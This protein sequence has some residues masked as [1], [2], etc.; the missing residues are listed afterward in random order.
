MVKER[1]KESVIR[2]VIQL[3][4]SASEAARRFH[5]SE[6]SA[7]R[8]VQNYRRSGNFGGRKAGSGSWKIS[9]PEQDARLVAEIQRNPFHTSAT[10]KAVVN[11]P[12]N[13]QTVVNRL[14]AANLRSRPV[15]P[16]EV[17]EEHIEQR[18]V[19]AAGND[20]QDWKKVIF[21]DEL[22]FSTTKEEPTFVYRPPGTR[23]DH[24]YSVI[25][26]RSCRVSV[27]CWG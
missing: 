25:H 23:F 13:E 3:C 26:A 2:A 22:T 12:G 1:N 21:S 5:V 18:S 20:D 4:F 9:T 14:R 10:L 6:R 15:I 16:R 24:R 17:H 27:S 7:R 19:F 8:W 11:L